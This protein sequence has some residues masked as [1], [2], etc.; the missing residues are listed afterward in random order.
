MKSFE[1]FQIQFGLLIFIYGRLMLKPDCRYPKLVSFF[2]VPQ[3]VFMLVL[4][5]DFYRR[6][7]LSKRKNY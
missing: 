4:F 7:Y 2:F 3:N 6:T 5:G 1:I